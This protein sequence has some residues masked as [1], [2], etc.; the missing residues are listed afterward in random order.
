MSQKSGRISQDMEPEKKHDK[1]SKIKCPW[2]ISLSVVKY[3][4]FIKSFTKIEIHDN[5]PHHGL[6]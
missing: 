1:M 4:W 3:A 5:V 2:L 6:D